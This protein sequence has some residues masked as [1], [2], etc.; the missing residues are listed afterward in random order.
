MRCKMVVEKI[1]RINDIE[2]VQ[3]QENLRLGAVYNNSP[4]NKEW[5]KWTPSANLY[6][7]ITNPNLF[8]KV[9]DGQEFYIDFTPLVF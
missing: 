1:E 7:S 9:F 6:I 8:N 3:I 5:S 4:E 2:G